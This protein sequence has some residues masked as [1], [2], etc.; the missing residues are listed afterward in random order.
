MTTNKYTILKDSAF[1]EIK[2]SDRELFLQG[3]I[4]NDIFQC[5]K[6]ISIYSA[7]LSPQGKFI[8]DFFIIN[9]GQSFL[10]ETK[11]KFIDDLII[12]LNFYK[13]RADVKINKIDSFYSIAIYE[14]NHL[15]NNLRENGDTEKLDSGYILVDPRKKLM[16]LKAFIKK[17]MLEKFIIKYSLSKDKYENYNKKRILNII[18][19][20]I[21]DLKINKSVLLEN[22]F[23]SINAISWNKGCYVGQEITARMKYRALIKKSIM[24][25]S[26]IKGKIKSDDEIFFEN[27]KIGYMCSVDENIG[28]AMLNIIDAKNLS[29]NNKILNT[30]NGAIKIQI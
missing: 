19:D 28:L 5:T 11:N 8:A 16:G 9:L 22:N 27:K 25:I 23:N 30:K 15:F 20:S 12:K 26:L 24:K 3:L 14:R 18:P 13:L 2:G 7:F 17:E 21:L 10:L 29:E 6:N 1:F 4:T